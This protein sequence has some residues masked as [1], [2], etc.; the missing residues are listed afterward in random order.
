MHPG[1]PSGLDRWGNWRQLNWRMG[2]WELGLLDRQEP[3]VHSVVYVLIFFSIFIFRVLACQA[4]GGGDALVH[5]G[6]EHVWGS[7]HQGC[8]PLQ[9][10][11]H[12]GNL[13]H[14]RGMVRLEA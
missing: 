6:Q 4:A 12:A 5:Q 3:T 1:S 9:G 11:Q 14:V 8:P 10:L 7:V 13:L 2:Y